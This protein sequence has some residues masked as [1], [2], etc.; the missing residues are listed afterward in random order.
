MGQSGPEEVL[1]CLGYIPLPSSTLPVGTE[2]CLTQIWGAG[3]SKSVPLPRITRVYP[4]RE[5]RLWVEREA[6]WAG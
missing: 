6:I 3:E 4:R 1:R 5:R 2:L